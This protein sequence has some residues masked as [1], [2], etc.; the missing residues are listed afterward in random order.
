MKLPPLRLS[1]GFVGAS[2]LA[3]LGIYGSTN[4]WDRMRIFDLQTAYHPLFIVPLAIAIRYAAGLDSVLLRKLGASFNAAPGG[5]E[6]NPWSFTEERTLLQQA[7]GLFRD[8]APFSLVLLLYP[9]SEL[10]VTALR[11]ET[12]MDSE[13]IQMEVALFGGHLSVWMERFISPG[14]TDFLSFC[15]LFHTLIPVIVLSFLCFF[16][17]RAEFVE[18]TEGFVVMFQIGLIL[19]VLVPASGPMQSIASS[20]S[21]DLSGGALTDLSRAAIEATRVPRDAFPS[22]HIGLSALLLLYAWRSSRWFGLLLLPLVV[23]NWIS[24][25]YLRYHYLVD[26]LAGFALV[27][28]VYRLAKW[29][30]SRNGL[31][32]ASP[33]VAA[34]TG[35]PH[36]A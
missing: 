6:V 14:L 30:R 12:R 8:V 5:T 16:R 36:A 29:A 9:A 3:M 18:A 2:F 27:P 31:D 26:V 17:S 1:E 21:R 25:I 24:T 32:P 33:G 28:I 19:Y 10:V 35:G 13:L 34:E 23:G 15:Y 22:L 4:S 7:A 11:G 20:Y